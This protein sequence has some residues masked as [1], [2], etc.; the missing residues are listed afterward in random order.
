MYHVVCRD[1]WIEEQIHCPEKLVTI[2]QPMS[3]NISEEKKTHLHSGRI[4]KRLKTLLR[5]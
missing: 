1:A 3:H 2:Y 4:L 5:T